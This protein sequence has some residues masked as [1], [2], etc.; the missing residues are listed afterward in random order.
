MKKTIW[1]YELPFPETQ[2]QMPM[3]AQVLDVQVQ[4]DTPCIWALVDQKL[5]LE[6]RKFKFFGTGHEIDSFITKQ[7]Y[8][9]TFQLREGLLIFHLFETT[10]F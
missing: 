3:G 10:K 7:N 2:L 8:V 6:I 5:K 9:G 4:N 1:K